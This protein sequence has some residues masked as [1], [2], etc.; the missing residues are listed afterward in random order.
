V[1]ARLNDAPPGKSV[2]RVCQTVLNLK[3]ALS[4]SG[5]ALVPGKKTML[6]LRFPNTA[7]RFE[8]GHRIRLVLSRSYW[9]QI[10]PMPGQGDL[11]IHCDGSALL[12][13]IR[14]ASPV[15]PPLLLPDSGKT[16][17]PGMQL[18]ENPALKRWTRFDRN[19]GKI[20]TGWHQPLRT[21]RFENIGLTFGVETRAEHTLLNNDA[22]SAVSSY[23]HRLQFLRKDGAYEV[24]GSAKLSITESSFVVSGSV[25]VDENDHRIF[26][27]E[28]TPVIPRKFS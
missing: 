8:R 28:W 26:T 21:V 6:H 11:H 7:Y 25:T 4:E 1:V 19:L 5:S 23:K 3:Q 2:A 22:S 9:P 17:I 24:T 16:E 14:P 13:P 18:I 10:V 15:E 12:L 27:R 20:S